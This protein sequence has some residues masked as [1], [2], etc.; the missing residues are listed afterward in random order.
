MSRT[1]CYC[2]KC[3]ILFQEVDKCSNLY[4]EDM[5]NDVNSTMCIRLG[6]MYHIPSDIGPVNVTR[7]SDKVL[8]VPVLSTNG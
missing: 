2:A 5:R 6:M 4:M 3:L 8:R 7:K 1:G